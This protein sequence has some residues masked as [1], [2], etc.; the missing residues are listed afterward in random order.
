VIFLSISPG[1]VIP[2]S[3]TKCDKCRFVLDVVF[4]SFR[5][6]RNSVTAAVCYICVLGFW[7]ENCAFAALSFTVLHYTRCLHRLVWTFNIVYYSS[8]LFWHNG[9]LMSM[10]CYYYY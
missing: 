4:I 9:R 1:A 3:Y 7:K 6:L 2:Q 8:L 10:L 5:T